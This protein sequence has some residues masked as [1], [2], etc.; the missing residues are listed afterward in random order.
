MNPLQLLAVVAFLPNGAIHAARP[1]SVVHDSIYALAVNPADYPKNDFVWLLDEGVYRIEPDGRWVRAIRQ[2]IQILKPQG[3]YPYREQALSYNPEHQ[4]LTVNWMRVVGPNGGVISAAPEQVQESDIPAAMG[5]PT[6]T[7]TKVRRM[8]LTGLDSGTVLDFSITTE[9]MKPPMPGDFFH[10]WRVTPGTPVRRSRLVV[11]VPVGF[12]PRIEEKNLNFKRTQQT[13]GGRTLYTWATDAVPLLKPELFAPDTG[14]KAMTVS[15]SP[16]RGWR[17]IGDWY[18]PIVAGRYTLGPTAADK[19]KSITSGAKSL[20]DSIAAIH[21][22]VSTDVRYVAITLAQG[23]YV[24]RD[25]ET[26]ARTGFG[27]C[28]DKTMLFLAALKS[29]GVTG[30][31]VLLNATAKVNEATPTLA[32]FNHMIAAVETENGFRYSD[33]TV[34]DVSFGE[35]PPLENGKFGLLL[36]DGTGKE[37]HLPGETLTP[38]AAFRRDDIR[39]AGTL[40]AD[41][42]FNGTIEQRISGANSVFL[43]MAA[44]KAAD[45]MMRAGFIRSIAGSLFEG[46]DGDSL[47]VTTPPDTAGGV[48]VRVRVRNARAATEVS[49]LELL[50]NPIRPYVVPARMIADLEKAP[51]RTMPIDLSRIAPASPRSSIAVIALPDGWHALLPKN[52]S[53]SGLLGDFS[54]S[55]AQVG[56]E[57]RITRTISGARGTVGAERIGDVIAALRQLTT[58]NARTIPIQKQ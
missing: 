19:I 23:G 1:D 28:K 20:R 45:S 51:P 55:F 52:S 29:I 16:P 25:A 42:Y 33:L 14:L 2:V 18:A 57:L 3:A 32:A 40:T 4:K 39:I 48:I 27:D 47:S 9:E 58:D 21:K 56:S 38:A 26:V 15:V 53:Y 24:P 54:I 44:G 6:Y 17:A 41:G 43:K 36:R 30:F 7:S 31:P 5:V 12:V 13:I 35:L 46:A 50:A 11:D 22:W 37:I 8:S 34:S 49:S 10:S